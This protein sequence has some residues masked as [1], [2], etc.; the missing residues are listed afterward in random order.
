[1]TDNRINR[2]RIYRIP[3]DPLVINTKVSEYGA[4]MVPVSATQEDSA[5]KDF[6]GPYIVV[7][8]GGS[9]GQ[10]GVNQPGVG[11][12]GASEIS[13]SQ[14]EGEGVEYLSYAAILDGTLRESSA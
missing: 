13:T 10:Q 6:V 12:S 14:V 4:D 8:M 5:P 2:Q 3:V 7:P 9:T 11:N 1:M